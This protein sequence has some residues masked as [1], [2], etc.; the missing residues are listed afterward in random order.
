M[1]GSLLMMQYIADPVLDLRTTFAEGVDKRPGDHTAI[2]TFHDGEVL[3]TVTAPA[4]TVA[5]QLACKAA[6][7]IEQSALQDRCT[8]RASTAPTPATTEDPSPEDSIMDDPEAEQES[9]SEASQPEGE[10]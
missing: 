7:R 1:S 3:A 2:C 9:A 10:A 4:K 8:C 6:L 5:R